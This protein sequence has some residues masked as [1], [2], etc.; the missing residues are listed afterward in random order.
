VPK[1]KPITASR[2]AEKVSSATCIS[3]QSAPAV[4]VW[5]GGSGERNVVVVRSQTT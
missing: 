1:T 3:V 4:N 2:L 5:D